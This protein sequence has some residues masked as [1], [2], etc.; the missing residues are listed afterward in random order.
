[1]C[2]RTLTMVFFMVLSLF[3]TMISHHALSQETGQD[4]R[5]PVSQNRQKGSTAQGR[6]AGRGQMDTEQ[7]MNRMSGRI[8]EVLEMSDEEWTVI[9]PKLINVVTLSTQSTSSNMGRMMGMFM[10]GRG[11]TN[12]RTQ[13]QPFAGRGEPGP[14]A[15][16][17]AELQKLL[18]DKEAPA[19]EIK[20][21]IIE[22]REAKEEAEQKLTTARNELRELLT[23]RQE[24]LLIAMGYLD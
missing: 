22:L 3:S 10:S 24:A 5:Q 19:S 7:M 11:D 23:V 20:R 16:V 15:T 21:K 17:Q 4:N 9:G 1:M 6:M 8:K 18:E 14:I 12:Q 2:K 13:R